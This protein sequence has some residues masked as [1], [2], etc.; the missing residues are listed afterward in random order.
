MILNQC[1]YSRTQLPQALYGNRASN[2]VILIS[3]KRQKGEKLSLNFRMSQG[4]YE[5]AIPEY[6]RTNVAQF[7]HAEY[8]NIAN[9]YLGNNVGKV[10]RSDKQAIFNHV[11]GNIFDDR[12]SAN[13]FNIRDA[14][15]LYT[16]DGQLVPGAAILPEVAGDLDWFDQ[17]PP[18][19]SSGIRAQRCRIFQQKRLLFL[20]QLPE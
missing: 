15:D 3:T 8:Q 9:V 11:I 16:L 10:D 18:W 20:R 12:L 5:R 2:G 6:D 4:W 13:Y 17:Y 14:K 7:M 19:L 1:P